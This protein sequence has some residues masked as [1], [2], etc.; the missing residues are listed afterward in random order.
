MYKMNVTLSN[1]VERKTLTKQDATLIE[2]ELRL[3]G[4][5]IVFGQVGGGKT[6][7]LEAIIKSCLEQYPKNK[8]IYIPLYKEMDFSAESSIEVLQQSNSSIAALAAVAVKKNAD[9]IFI[10]EIRT[11]QDLLAIE[12][13]MK[14][15]KQVIF[16]IH[17]ATT[18]ALQDKLRM[19]LLPSEDNS[20]F[21][22]FEYILDQLN[23]LIHAEYVPIGQ[24]KLTLSKTDE[25]NRVTHSR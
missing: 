17:A 12:F 1:L 22:S 9:T 21:K 3:R 10:E 14:L 2:D 8:H 7:I 23:M 13:L 20:V 19:L 25:L 4:N 5:M 15:G 11:H 24:Y 16:T 18:S 6:T